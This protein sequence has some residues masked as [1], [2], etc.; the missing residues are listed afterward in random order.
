MDRVGVVT[1]VNE[2]PGSDGLNQIGCGQEWSTEAL[3]PP[4]GGV[5]ASRF[6]CFHRAA[7]QPANLLST[8]TLYSE[9]E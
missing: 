8:L 2:D 1:L 5:P 6:H 4:V 3:V 9:I 7:S